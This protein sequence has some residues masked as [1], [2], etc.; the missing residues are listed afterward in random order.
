MMNWLFAAL[1]ASTAEEEAA[2][3][4]ML[5]LAQKSLISDRPLPV[6]PLGATTAS[7]RK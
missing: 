1:L 3:V 6:K 2:M 7:R 5:T 4:R